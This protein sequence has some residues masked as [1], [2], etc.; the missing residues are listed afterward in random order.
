MKSMRSIAIYGKGGIGK[1]TITANLSVALAEK[2]YKVLQIGCDPKHDSTRLLLGGFTQSTVLEL[3]KDGSDSPSLG[4]VLMTGYKGIKCIEAG[5]PE[6]GVGCAGRGIISMTTFLKNS[7][8]KVNDFDLVIYDVLGDVVCGGFGVPMRNEYSNEIY[9]ISSGELMSI[10][11]ANNISKGI[12]NFS[13]PKGKL[14]GIIG[15]ERGVK[16]ER[17]LLDEF[18]RRL[19]S[20]LLTIFARNEIFREAEL[21]CMTIM[22]YAPGSEIASQFRALAELIISAPTAV[23]PTPLGEDELV[24]LN[25]QFT[26]AKVLRRKPKAKRTVEA[27][28]QAPV[29]FSVQRRELKREISRIGP[30]EREPLHGCTLGGA[31]N[32]TGQVK[33]C[34]SVMHSPAGCAY[35]SIDGLMSIGTR[36]GMSGQSHLLPN[37]LSTSIGEDDVV[38]GGERHLEELIREAHRRLRPRAF[39][40]ITSCPVS[41]IGDNW[42][43]VVSKLLKDGIRVVSI[44]T[45][46]IIGGDY[47]K[48]MINA[49]AAL[50]KEFIDPEVA[51]EEG[52]VNVVGERNTSKFADRN[53]A[54]MKEIFDAL[55]LRVNCRFIRDTT[56]QELQNFLRGSLSILAAND[57][58]CAELRKILS[59]Y[60]GEFFDRSFPIGFEETKVFV[61]RLGERYAKEGLAG[62]LLGTAEDEY[63]SSVKRLK[64]ALSGKRVMI[65]SYAQDLDWLIGTLLDLEMQVLK[66]CIYDSCVE[67]AFISR[68]ADSVDVE[69]S[70]PAEKRRDDIL[71]K[72]PDLVLTNYVPKEVV[73]R[74]VYDVV[75]LSPLNGFYGPLE[76]ARRWVQKIR[77]PFQE[78]WREDAKLFN[79]PS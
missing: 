19:G 4:D 13:N 30:E 76:H 69:T 75:P 29:D 60:G 52:H 12:R 22:E 44:Q 6:P 14:A 2:G 63:R 15:N 18:A 50:A 46:G 67:S 31:F 43:Q 26:D 25:L 7:G 71:D 11:A 53:F 61:E 56:T 42:D 9:V 38:F 66:L 64:K 37:L 77:V 62:E 39:F 10:Y 79:I 16:G 23:L 8:L 3:L 73:G 49:Y 17:Q 72:G 70:Y 78:G 74:A 20:R 1:S 5:G 58:L 35:M 55:G 54:A 21:N 51:A 24:E 28:V 41:I 40:L 32:V 34:L 45:E 68:Y 59:D 57:S 27:V 36:G 65:F 48:G 47:Q 33:D